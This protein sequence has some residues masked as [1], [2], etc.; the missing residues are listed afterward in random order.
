MAATEIEIFEETE[1]ERIRSWRRGELMRAGYARS[2]ASRLARR[3]DNRDG[4]DRDRDLRGDRGGADPL[5]AARRAHAGRLCEE[6]GVEARA[7]T[8]RRSAPGDQA[9]RSRLLARAGA[10]DSPV[11]GLLG[12]LAPRSAQCPS[13]VP[14]RPT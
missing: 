4:C 10:S 11:A 13:R 1:E 6:R 7:A 14:G 8:R 9:P 3:L 2:A 12:A 5:L